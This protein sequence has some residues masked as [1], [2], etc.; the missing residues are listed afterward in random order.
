LRVKGD[1]MIEAGILNGDYVV[2]RPQKTIEN[3]E[4]GVVLIDDE[5]TIKRV[6]KERKKIVLKPENKDMKPS[7]HNPDEVS[8]IGRV[9]GVIRKM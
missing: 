7:M 1:S 8:I 4:I 2:V 9:V 6:F 3:G 5:A